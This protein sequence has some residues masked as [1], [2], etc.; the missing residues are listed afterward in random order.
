M[1]QEKI[2]TKRPDRSRDQRALDEAQK[3]E[4][5]QKGRRAYRI[6]NGV[7]ITRNPDKYGGVILNNRPVKI[8]LKT[9]KYNG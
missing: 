6:L 3:T 4:K 2:D 5:R 8:N 9:Y 7:I 1:K